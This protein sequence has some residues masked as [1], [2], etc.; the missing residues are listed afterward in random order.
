MIKNI[1]IIKNLK[2]EEFEQKKANLH[3]HTTYSDG[4]ATFSDIVKQAKDKN[5]NVIAITDHNTVQGHLD[6]PDENVI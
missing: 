6:F 4:S 3:I 1:E 5:Y 2:K